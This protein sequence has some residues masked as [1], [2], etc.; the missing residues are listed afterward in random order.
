MK[1]TMLLCFALLCMA[2][3]GAFADSYTLT[4]P[5]GGV[6]GYGAGG[7]RGDIITMT[8]D[9]TLTSIGI[10]GEINNGAQMTFNAYVYD[11][12]GGSGVIPLAVGQT[13]Y[14]PATEPNS[15]TTCPS[16]SP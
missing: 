9:F 4:P 13:W 11:D 10:Q 2:S 16:A 5:T 14:S 6:L 8:G 3:A 12:E 1:R 15:S 7:T